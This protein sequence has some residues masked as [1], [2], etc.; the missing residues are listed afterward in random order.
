MS[1]LTFKRTS[2][3]CLWGGIIGRINRIQWIILIIDQLASRIPNI[4]LAIHALSFIK[5]PKGVSSE[6]L[7]F[8]SFPLRV[9]ASIPIQQVRQARF[10]TSV[11]TRP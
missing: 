5:D 11:I 8:S 7:L 4:P 6:Y 10:G 2:Q 3:C 9:L 1:C